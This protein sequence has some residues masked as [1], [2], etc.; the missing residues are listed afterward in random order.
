MK[1]FVGVPEM[2]VNDASPDELVTSVQRI[3]GPCAACGRAITIAA[4]QRDN[5]ARTGSGI[6]GRLCCRPTMGL[7]TSCKAPGARPAVPSKSVTAVTFHV[8]RVALA[9]P[10]AGPRGT[11]VDSFIDFPRG[12][13]GHSGDE[14]A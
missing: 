8:A 1:S 14:G 10:A 4:M 2:L 13:E 9:V 7:Y 12:L 6:E 5:D 11:F 3:R